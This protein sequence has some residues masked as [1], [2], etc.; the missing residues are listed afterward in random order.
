MCLIAVRGT[1]RKREVTQ[2][3]QSRKATRSCREH[4]Q[5]TKTLQGIPWQE[6]P[7]A[8]AGESEKPLLLRVRTSEL[9]RGGV[10]LLEGKD[11]L[12]HHWDRRPKGTCRFSSVDCCRTGS[13]VSKSLKTQ[14]VRLQRPHPQR[15]EA[16]PGNALCGALI[17]APVQSTVLLAC[18]FPS[19]HYLSLIVQPHFYFRK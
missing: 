2:R 5:Q 11:L 17:R 1:L 4:L 16:T 14:T 9:Q 15:E 12:F 13:S 3:R 19:C 18:A 10:L 6:P 8:R 7:R